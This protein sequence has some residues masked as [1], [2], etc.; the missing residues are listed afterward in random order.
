M[1]IFPVSTS[2]NTTGPGGGFAH[3]HTGVY[4]YH[5]KPHHG[6]RRVLGYYSRISNRLVLGDGFGHGPASVYRPNVIE[7]ANG[8]D[9]VDP[10]GEETA[11]A[12]E[13]L[14]PKTVSCADIL[15][16]AA[17]DAVTLSGGPNWN[18][19]KGRKDG[20]ISKATDTRQL[21]GPT[22]NISQLQQR[23]SQRGLGTEDLVAL[24]GKKTDSATNVNN[25]GLDVV[26]STP[27]EAT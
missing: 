26:A 15:A 2:N 17:R 24:S 5:P 6:A 12:L 20:R 22:F 4:R 8:I 3:G 21:P 16:L 10:Y 19:P 14:C 23:F 25:D 13:V 9:N 11:K 7:F 27:N 18:V 1:E